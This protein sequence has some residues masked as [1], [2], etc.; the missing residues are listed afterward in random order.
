MVSIVGLSVE[1]E[2][3]VQL[4]RQEEMKLSKC[5]RVPRWTEIARRSSAA[6]CETSVEGDPTHRARNLN[7][8][9]KFH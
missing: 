5:L 3:E 6:R 7:D 8:Y 9:G 2:I 1:P 4:N